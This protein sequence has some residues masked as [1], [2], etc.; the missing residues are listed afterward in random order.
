MKKE[1]LQELKK[2]NPDELRLLEKELRGKI[3]SLRFALRSG[4]TASL[5]DIK[6]FK[7]ERAITL[8]ILQAYD[9]Q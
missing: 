2:K 1:R 3:L 7:K 8:T 4:K 5:K 6:N 9:K